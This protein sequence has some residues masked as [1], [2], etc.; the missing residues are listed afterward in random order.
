MD[1]SRYEV[2]EVI[3]FVVSPKGNVENVL[4]IMCYEKIFQLRK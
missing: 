3:N 2:M 1:N 4:I